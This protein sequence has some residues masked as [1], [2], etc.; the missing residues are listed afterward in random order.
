MYPFL[1]PG[2]T[3][4]CKNS[5]SGDDIRIGD[6]V[7]TQVDGGRQTA[8]RVI[9]LS[10]LSI[11]GDNL[12]VADTFPSGDIRPGEIVTDIKRGDRIFHVRGRKQKLI[13][14]LSRYNLTPGI[15]KSRFVTG[16]LKIFIGIFSGNPGS[17]K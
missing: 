11:K 5:P 13:A 7:V 9:K 4:L 15:L 6:I 2:D 17:G 12:P 14:F 16:P 1:R 8:H 10:P 3:L